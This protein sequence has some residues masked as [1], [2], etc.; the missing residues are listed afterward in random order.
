[1]AT[2]VPDGERIV[3]LE[4]RV[5][6]V[7]D[8]VRSIRHDVRDL[9]DSTNR[10][11]EKLNERLISRPSWPVTIYITFTTSATVGLLV[12]YLSTVK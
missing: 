8:D 4:G 9:A 2:M 10:G 11:F 12:A 5:I 6:G 7:E 3:A 1:M